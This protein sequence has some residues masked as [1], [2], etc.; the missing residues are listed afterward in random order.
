MNMLHRFNLAVFPALL[1]TVSL[2][3]SAGAVSTTYE[4]Q[5]DTNAYV[6][7]QWLMNE[8]PMLRPNVLIGVRWTHTDSS[9]KVNGAD[10][11]LSFSTD[12]MKINTLRVGYLQGECDI[13]GTIGLGY[14]FINNAALAYAG[15]LGSYYKAFG[16]ID[17]NKKLDAGL[18][19]NSQECIGHRKEV[20]SAPL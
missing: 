18:E 14:S 16:Q 17:M 15:V 2:T 12:K 10:A 20:N 7:V 19:L 5:E 13:Q 6:G 8:T 11:T 3:T 4:S 1:I 9:D